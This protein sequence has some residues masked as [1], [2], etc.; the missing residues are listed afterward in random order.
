M[1]YNRILQTVILVVMIASVANAQGKKK[2]KN[3][4]P[5]NDYPGQRIPEDNPGYPQYPRYPG[6]DNPVYNDPNPRNLPPGQAKK[7]YGGKSAKPYAPGQRKKQG[8]NNY[9]RNDGNYRSYPN[10]IYKTR[11]YPL[12]I[13]R[14]RDM[15]IERDGSGRL[16]YRHPD[17]IIYWKGNDDRYYLDERYLSYARYTQKEYD[18]WKYKGD[19]LSKIRDRIG[20]GKRR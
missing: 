6:N 9:E 2:S 4:Y 8:Y 12:I 10:D 7:I 17:G 16:Y 1:I 20:I 15:I 13:K 19:T 11:T 18:D 3:R 14:T 5:S